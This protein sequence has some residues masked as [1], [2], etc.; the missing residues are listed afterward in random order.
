MRKKKFIN[1]LYKIKSRIQIRMEANNILLKS[2]FINNEKQEAFCS[3]M[4]AAYECDM[5]LIDEIIKRM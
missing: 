5:Q 3:G 1:K 4:S 2:G